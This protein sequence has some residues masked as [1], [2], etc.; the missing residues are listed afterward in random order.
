VFFSKAKRLPKLSQQGL[1]LSGVTAIAQTFG[2]PP[3]LVRDA[4][5]E[6]GNVCFGTVSDRLTLCG[7]FNSGPSFLADIFEE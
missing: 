1:G 2:D 6:L 3:L 4:L 5:L 7:T